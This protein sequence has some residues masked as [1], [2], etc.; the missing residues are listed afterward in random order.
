MGAPPAPPAAPPLLRGCAAGWAWLALLWWCSQ[1]LAAWPP[2]AWMAALAVLAAPVAWGLWLA[3][4]VRKRVLR[5]QWAD[6]GWL[7]RWLSGGLWAA[8]KATAL[9]LALAAAAL[10]QGYFLAS[11]EWA[12]L[13]AAA[14]LH[15]ALARAAHARLTPQVSHG[16]Y[17]WRWNQWL[18]RVLVALL[19]G[20]AWLLWWAGGGLQGRDLVPAM[21]PQ[22]LDAAL[23][24]IAHAP[25]GLVR[26]GLDALLAL[27]VGSGAALALPQSSGWRLA[28]LAVTGPLSLLWWLGGVQ[29]GASASRAVWRAVRPPPLGAMVTALLGML[30]VLIIV[31]T[32]ARLDGLAREHPSPLA[33]QRLAS[34][35]RI[36]EHYYRLGTLDAVRRLSEQALRQ[37]GADDALCA[38]LQGL[39]GALDA[40]LERYL[41][42]YFSL[43][44]EWGRIF[45]L[46]GG[47]AE[48]YLQDQLEATLRATPG[49]D[50]WTRAAQ[51]H[52]LQGRAAL[53]QGRQRIDE[54]LA[55][56]HLSLDGRACLV[57]AQAPQPPQLEGLADAR[58]RLSAR[59]LGGAGAGAFAAAVA[60][61]A[62]GKTSMKAAAKV[63]AKAA[64]KQGLGKAGGAAVGAGVGAAA[65]SA[66]PIVGTAV[67][68]IAGAAAGLATGVAID[69]AA[70]RLEEHLTREDMR[71]QLRGALAES[72]ASLGDALACGGHAAMR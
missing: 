23:A 59:A 10:W 21:D 61:K 36:G 13:G 72:L 2:W 69:W 14:P 47:G 63:L 15:A 51:Q 50:R 19:V 28:L 29:Q 46:L 57:R 65:G 37:A 41:D 48:R 44:A 58:Q 34:C 43:G 54:V 24:A 27:Q 12:L 26:W 67:G 22:A 7:G 71:A 42:W 38:D 6:T 18:A 53:D 3:F 49:L 62:M 20:A 68:A 45:H 25:S 1:R 31:P 39:H 30:A 66:V 4:M 16:A 56:H 60:G 5:A 9:A 33:L 64:A 55:R 70:L 11:W 35:E 40:A 32:L 17:A 8:C 52:A